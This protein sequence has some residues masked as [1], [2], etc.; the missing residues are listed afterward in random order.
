MMSLT[1]I[2]MGSL[3]AKQYQFKLKAYVGLFNS[4]MVLQLLAILFS[5]GGSGQSGGSGGYGLQVSISY[6][7]ADLVVVFTILWAFISAILITTKAYRE[8]DFTFVTNRVSGNLS[9]VLLLG[10]ASIL[11]GAT[12]LMAGYLIKVLMYYVFDYNQVI[13]IGPGPSL[14]EFLIGLVATILTVFLFSSLG[15]LIGTLVQQNR[16][17]VIVLPVIFFGLLIVGEQTLKIYPLVSIG[18]FYFQESSFWLF[19]SKVLITIALLFS[20]AVMMSNRMEVR[21]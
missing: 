18:E 7:S 4:L 12:A 1:T 14:Q 11:G 6:Y 8:D 3:V 19:L 15:Y 17:F 16:I 21:R 13:G 20:G 9:N 5:F 10:T 2:S